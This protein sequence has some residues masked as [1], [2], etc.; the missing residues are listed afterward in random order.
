M[1]L[2]R[3]LRLLLLASSYPAARPLPP[4]KDIST[5]SPRRRSDPHDQQFKVVEELSAQVIVFSL[6]GV[7]QGMNGLATGFRIFGRTVHEPVTGL[8]SL[9]SRVVDP[10]GNVLVPGV[11]DMRRG[12]DERYVPLCLFFIYVCVFS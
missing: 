12:A 10:A 5:R 2:S 8:I 3:A 4:P 11:D 1:S 7:S 6:S 9:M